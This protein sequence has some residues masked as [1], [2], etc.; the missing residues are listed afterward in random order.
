[1]ASN[2]HPSSIRW[3]TDIHSSPP[4]V[5]ERGEVGLSAPQSKKKSGEDFLGAEVVAQFVVELLQLA[6]LLC[7]LGVVVPTGVGQPS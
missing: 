4:I 5:D 7:P 3:L 2:K 1:M 6:E